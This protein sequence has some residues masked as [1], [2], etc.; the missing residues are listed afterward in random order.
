MFQLI[1]KLIILTAALPFAAMLSAR[2]PEPVRPVSSAWMAEVGSSHLADTYLSPIRYSG[3]HYG[4]TY[5]RLQAMKS[6]LLPCV[7]GWELG[8]SFDK[9]R[10]R[11][12]NATMLG[13]RVDGSWRMMRRW[14]LPLGFQAGVGGYVGAEFGALY[15]SRNSNNPAQAIGAAGIGPEGFVQ[16]AGQLKKLPLAVRWQL[17]SPLVGAFFCPDYGELYYEIQLGNRSDLVHFAWPG[18]RR[19]VRSLLSV[20][21][22]FGRSTLRLG[23][24]FNALSAKANNVTSRRISHAAVVGIVCDLV[25]INPRKSDANILPAYY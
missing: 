9:T 23:Y 19:S 17:S 14:Q 5:S 22:N 7:Q 12:G 24:S 18:S 21:L 10:N 20:D 3:M 16:W 15:L 4:L 8:L 2:E 11:A 6:P 25:T 13:A 1:R